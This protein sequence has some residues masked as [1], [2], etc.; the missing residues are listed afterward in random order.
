MC[1]HVAF[2]TVNE[3]AAEVLNMCIQETKYLRYLPN[4]ALRNTLCT[5]S[6]NFVHCSIAC[7]F[8]LFLL[9]RRGRPKTAAGR[10]IFTHGR[11]ASQGWVKIRI[12]QA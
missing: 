11:G 1:F 5:L 12:R 3:V 9:C 4:S 10:G 6:V 8:V 2:I 7:V